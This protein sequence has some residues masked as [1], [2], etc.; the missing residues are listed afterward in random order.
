MFH[1]IFLT[2][3]VEHIV[4][5]DDVPRQQPRGP[6]RAVNP[7]RTPTDG[8]ARAVSSL[9]E[10]CRVATEVDEV[11]LRRSSERHPSSLGNG[12]VATEE[13][14]RLMQC[15]GQAPHTK[16]DKIQMLQFHKNSFLH[17]R[18]RLGRSSSA[19]LLPTGRKKA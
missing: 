10:Y 3:G 1:H 17:Y 11:N 14:R 13:N 5:R 9:L 15:I 4:A 8:A 19:R 6:Q 2:E 12:R 7:R 16:R 18:L